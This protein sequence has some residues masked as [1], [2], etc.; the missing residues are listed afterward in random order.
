[1][2]EPSGIFW[3]WKGLEPGRILEISIDHTCHFN[4]HMAGIPGTPFLPQIRK[5]G[6]YYCLYLRI[7][8]LGIREIHKMFQNTKVNRRLHARNIAVFM[9]L[10]KCI[11]QGHINHFIQ[12]KLTFIQVFLLHTN[13][14]AL[15][16]L[17]SNPRLRSAAVTAAATGS[18][19]GPV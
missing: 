14:D 4:Y 3:N 1:M 19:A 13:L 8:I 9:N 18:N 5:S 6:V 11:C 7:G 12:T 2:G 10:V 16:G 15:A 17:N